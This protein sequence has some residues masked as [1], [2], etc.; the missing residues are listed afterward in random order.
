M[1]EVASRRASLATLHGRYGANAMLLDV[2]SRGVDPWV[3][4]SP[5]YPH[6]QIP[7]PFSPDVWSQS[8]EGVWQGLKV[9]TGA[10]VDPTKFAVTTMRGIKRSAR[11]WGAVLGHREGVQGERLLPYAE[12]RLAIYVPSYRWV[13]DHRL[14]E[15]L[16]T[17]R[18]MLSEYTVV[19]L[20]YETNGDVRDLARPLSH[21]WLIKHYLEGTWPA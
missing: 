8:V 2:T 16:S 13:L 1:L 11:Q 5:F 12:A 18:D 21:A 17:L 4:F 15:Q 14:S 7:V 9:F 20:D 19:L 10:D 3:R 6:G